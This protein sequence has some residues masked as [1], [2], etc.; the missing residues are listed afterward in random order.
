MKNETMKNVAGIILFYMLIV[1]G[2]VI[3]NAR[4]STTSEVKSTITLNN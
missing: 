3:L 4:V 2:V 1:F